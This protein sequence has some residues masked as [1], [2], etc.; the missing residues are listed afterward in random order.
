MGLFSKITRGLAKTRDSFTGGLKSIFSGRVDEE[1]FEELEEA[2]ITADVGVQTSLKLTERLRQRAKAEHIRERD[3]LWSVLEEEI[4]ALLSQNGAGGLKLTEG[5]LNIV[6]LTGVNGAGKTTTIGKLASRW[7]QEGRSVLL[8]AAD[9]YRAAAAEQ[10]EGWAARSGA[11][12]IR[13]GEGA[14]PAAVVYDAIAAARARGTDVL[15]VDTAGRLQNKTNL[16][17]ELA[18]I[19]RVIGREAP[20][21]AVQTLLVLDGGTGQNAISQARLFAQAA[22]LTGLIITKLDGSAKGG[23]VCG[24]V[25]EVGLPV[26]LIG[27][28]EGIDDLREFD[29]AAYAHAMFSEDE[30]AGE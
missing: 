24:M 13:Q 1:F 25:D 16:M 6:M 3:Q 26:C 2:L 29:P 5:C 18:K 9:T 19:S 27:V 11:P 14:D 4:A 15:I 22:P 12:L 23:A 30:E 21:A 20:D 17:Q 8:A 7:Q 28:G 10:L